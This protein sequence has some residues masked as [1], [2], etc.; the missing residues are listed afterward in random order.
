MLEE[1]FKDEIWDILHVVKVGAEKVLHPIVQ[2]EGLTVIQT[3]VLFAV[4]KYEI[5]TV[6][7]LSKIFEINQGNVST[8]CKKLERLGFIYRVRQSEDERIVSLSLTEHGRQ[9]LKNIRERAKKYDPILRTIPKEKFQVI[10]NGFSELNELF[11]L[12]GAVEVK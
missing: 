6:G 3:Y 2:P 8:T 10:L 1:E 4:Q 9:A 11:K 12:L 7:N 5:I